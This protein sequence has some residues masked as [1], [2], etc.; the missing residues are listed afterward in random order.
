VSSL[1]RHMVT[2]LGLEGQAIVSRM[3]KVSMGGIGGVGVRELREV[4][5]WLSFSCHLFLSF[6][7]YLVPYKLAHRLVYVSLQPL[8]RKYCGKGV[9]NST[10][11]TSGGSFLDQGI[12]L[13]ALSY[14]TPQ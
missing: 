2:D 1:L 7:L 5:I 3:S 9:G 4:C 6:P 12:A 10:Y 14:H 13:V 11:S 8:N